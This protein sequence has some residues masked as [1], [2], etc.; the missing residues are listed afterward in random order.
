[1]RNFIRR[2]AQDAVTPSGSPDGFT[3]SEPEDCEFAE[4]A[5]RL[6]TLQYHLVPP[7]Q[8]W[9]AARDATPD[10]VHSWRDIPAVPTEAFKEFDFS[11]L[12]IAERSSRF[13]SSGTTQANR[14]RH[15]HSPASLALYE[16]SLL[17]WFKAHLLP[18]AGV[19]SPAVASRG[20]A[21]TFISL[22]PPAQ[23]APHSS[24]VHM[25]ETVR[26]QIAFSAGRFL[27]GVDGTGGWT[28]D[29]P[30][31]A[32]LL[33]DC[34]GPVLLAGTAFSCVALLDHLD[35]MKQPLRLPPGSRLVETG[36]YKGRSRALSK[37]ELHRL[38]TQWL[39]IA[40]SSIVSEY[41]MCEL[42]SQAYN[43]VAGDSTRQNRF[44]FPP[45]A[46]AQVISPE[47][48]REVSDGQRG[49]LR[50]ADLANV[51]SVLAVQTADLA[52]RRGRRFELLGRA[53][54]VEARGCSLLAETPGPSA[55]GFASVP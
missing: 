55:S 40:P 25:F 32:A 3:A 46:R 12:P 30:Q 13:D 5:L 49:L 8:R 6:F 9:C 43:G 26:D 17:P 10:R 44:Q 42:S 11:S 7:Y 16:A 35:E 48:G 38:I 14:S 24:L 2:S 1:L 51:Y 29:L 41:G 34:S 22:T 23:L 45:W 15:F 36:G 4:L 18:E 19:G 21:L 20:D 39:G 28:L 31:C 47:T 27:G 54:E 50:I 33:G 52:I 37:E 53:Q